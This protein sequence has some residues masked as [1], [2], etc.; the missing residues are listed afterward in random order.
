MKNDQKPPE[1]EVVVVEPIIQTTP[2]GQKTLIKLSFDNNDFTL[3]EEQIVNLGFQLASMLPNSLKAQLASQLITA[4][5]TT[6][7]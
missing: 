2:D 1:P 4:L 3:T 5:G 6:F 7:R